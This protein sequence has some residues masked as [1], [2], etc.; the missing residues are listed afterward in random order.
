MLVDFTI[1]YTYVHPAYVCEGTGSGHP[2]EV[3]K[4]Q[5]L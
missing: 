3:K 5:A 1:Y 2:D 4:A